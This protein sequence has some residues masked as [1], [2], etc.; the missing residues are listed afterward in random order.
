MD[1]TEYYIIKN[2]IYT[3]ESGDIK[4][5][6]KSVWVFLKIKEIMLWKKIMSVIREFIDR[7]TIMCQIF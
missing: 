4:E 5:D 1:L 2:E 7:Y 3:C 6:D